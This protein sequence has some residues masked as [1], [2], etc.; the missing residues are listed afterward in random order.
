MSALPLTETIC[1][2]FTL[3]SHGSQVFIQFH[4][5]DFNLKINGLTFRFSTSNSSGDSKLFIKLFKLMKL[6]IFKTNSIN[7]FCFGEH[8]F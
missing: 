2:G 4:Q 1:L 3:F 8:F 7:Y 6:E 5:V